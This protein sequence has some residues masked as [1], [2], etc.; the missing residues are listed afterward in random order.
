MHTPKWSHINKA[1]TAAALLT[2]GLG[3]SL[4]SISCALA[5]AMALALALA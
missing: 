3:F 5:M 4:G 1:A 2:P